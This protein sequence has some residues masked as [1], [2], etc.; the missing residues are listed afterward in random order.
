[1][2]AQFTTELVEKVYEKLWVMW[3]Y[4]IDNWATPVQEKE[5]ESRDK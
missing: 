4:L 2:E 3:Q 5:N 1:M